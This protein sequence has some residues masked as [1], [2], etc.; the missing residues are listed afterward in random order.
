MSQTRT[1]IISVESLKN[2]MSLFDKFV[3][4]QAPKTILKELL[5]TKENKPINYLGLKYKS[6]KIYCKLLS[7]CKNLLWSPFYFLYWYMWQHS[8]C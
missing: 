3:S 5:E 6:V 1:N 2:R 4:L 8:T 7:T